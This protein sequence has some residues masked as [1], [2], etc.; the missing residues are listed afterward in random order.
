MRSRGN[1]AIIC[2]LSANDVREGFLGVGANSFLMKPLPAKKESLHAILAKLVTTC[3]QSVENRSADQ[4]IQE[5]DSKT[6]SQDG[7]RMI[8]NESTDSDNKGNEAHPPSKPGLPEKLKVLFVD[9]DKLLRK[10][11]VRALSKA[12]P[13]WEVAQAASGEDALTMCADQTFQLIFMDQYSK[14]TI[15]SMLVS[16]VLGGSN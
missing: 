6:D 3:S 5:P 16:S 4:E 7:Q 2:G 9:D 13:N 11:V 12:Q 14:F 15:A 1:S 8:S 10:L